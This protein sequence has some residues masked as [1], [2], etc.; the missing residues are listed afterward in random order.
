[1]N[2]QRVT[3]NDSITLMHTYTI[4]ETNRWLS[5]TDRRRCGPDH[6]LKR[7]R[8]PRRVSQFDARWELL[9]EGRVYDFIHVVQRSRREAGLD[10]TDRIVLTVPETERDLL[11]HQD[12][13]KGETL[14]TRLEIGPSLEVR[15]DE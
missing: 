8:A 3:S 4:S 11:A 6:P 7:S 12:W 15:K 1:M 13:I 10:I 9:L 5:L 2:D 14:T